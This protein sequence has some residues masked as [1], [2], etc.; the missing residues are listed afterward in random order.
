MT[1]AADSD[2][3]GGEFAVEVISTG[4]YSSG[5]GQLGD[6]R[7]FAFHT[8]RGLLVVEVYRPRLRNPVPHAED[9]VAVSSRTTRDIDLTDE[10][11]VAA[12]VRDAVASAQPVPRNTS[13]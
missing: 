10:R 6:G 5:F 9:I 13:R 8:E 1:V 11:S 3:A 2:T 4:M 7:S 12:A